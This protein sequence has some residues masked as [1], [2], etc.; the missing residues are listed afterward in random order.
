MTRIHRTVAT[1][2]LLSLLI[3]CLSQVAQAQSRTPPE[4][5]GKTFIISGRI[6]AAGVALKGLP[7]DPVTDDQGNY[8]AEV[9]CD[10]SGTVTPVKEGYGFEP[11]ARTFNPV[12]E[13]LLGQDFRA[14][15]L[16]FTISGNVGL[17][18]VLLE[19]L[20]GPVVSDQD[21]F[22]RAR[23]DYGWAG[24]INP[25]KEGYAFTP[26]SKA[27]ERVTRDLA[28][29]DF[30][31]EVK[32]M[33]IMDEI[34]VGDEPVQGVRVTA[35]PGD[36]SAVTN[37]QG[38]YTIKVPYGWTGELRLAK[39][40]WEF[41][42]PSMR[43]DDVTDDIVGGELASS[44]GADPTM[45]RSRMVTRLSRA[46][47]PDS[48]G[49]VLVIPTTAV[50]SEAFAQIAEDMRVMLDILRETLSEPRT[51][52][53]VLYDYGD[54]FGDSGRAVEALYIQGYAA[55]FMMKV[56]FPFSFTV[57]QPGQVEAP[58]QE[59]VDPVWQRARDRLYS[60]QAG[61][62]YGTRGLSGEADTRSFDQ[63][64]GDLLR[65]LKHAANIRNVEPN[66]SI[67]LT[68]IGQGQE[69]VQ[70]GLAG[71][72]T[73][74]MG[75]MGGAGGMGGYGGMM[76][77]MGGTMGGYSSSG[78]GSFSSRGSFGFG[79]GGGVSTGSRSTARRASPRRSLQSPAAS[80]STTV[81]TMQA[82]KSDIDAFAQGGLSFEQFQQK[83]K[84]F[85]Y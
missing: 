36:Y 80:P 37:A 66:E 43:Y 56:D 5:S 84:V 33:V 29:L 81:L 10:W 62:P 30:T 46:A 60:P 1:L 4:D 58:K 20:P 3:P 15:V 75:M 54:F 8:S 63:F 11:P 50:A 65:S 31:G 13:D 12:D 49:D 45:P 17:P 18:G 76:G 19:G 48:G 71:G 67:I 24:T 22:Y 14:E 44:P 28:R 52:S 47:V 2:A 34:L 53:G 6:G 38:R 72:G 32:M 69:G 85:T 23:L 51:I 35:E 83:V 41:D 78:G 16:R 74:G 42:P 26:P 59:A 57:Q 73:Y 77:G 40:G 82:Q 7:G 70:S 27:V 9:L 55:V 21:G 68:V 39:D 64:K 79:G 61:T 25:A